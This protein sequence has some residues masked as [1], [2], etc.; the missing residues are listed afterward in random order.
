MPKVVNKFFLQLTDVVLLQAQASAE[1]EAE[2]AGAALEAA[3]SAAA[4][5][6]RRAVEAE[7]KLADKSAGLEEAEDKLRTLQVLQ[8]TTVSPL[9]P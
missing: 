5:N 7:E 8:M 3:Q 1:R 9:L 4:A 2:A 6:E